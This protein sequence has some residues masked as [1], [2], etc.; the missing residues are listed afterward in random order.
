MTETSFTEYAAS[1]EQVLSA[2][3]EIIRRMA[4]AGEMHF[5]FDGNPVGF[6]SQNELDR[7]CDVPARYQPVFGT[8]ADKEVVLYHAKGVVGFGLYDEKHDL[9][10][11][12]SIRELVRTWVDDPEPEHRE[13]LQALLGDVELVIAHPIHP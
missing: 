1:V 5:D 11:P 9:C 12:V 10:Y 8:V 4:A 3:V 13:K 6:V 2:N 7:I